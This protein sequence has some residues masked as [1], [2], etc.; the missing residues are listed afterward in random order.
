MTN[1]GTENWDCHWAGHVHF[2]GASLFEDQI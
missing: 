1:N 2:G